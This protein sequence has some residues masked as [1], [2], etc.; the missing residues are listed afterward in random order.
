MAGTYTGAP[1]RREREKAPVRA[2][3]LLALGLV[4]VG[5][6]PAEAAPGWSSAP[7][8]NLPRE[9]PPACKRWKHRHG[10]VTALGRVECASEADAPALPSPTPS[11]APQPRPTERPTGGPGVAPTPTPVPAPSPAPAPA[12]SRPPAPRPSP[13]GRAPPPIAGYP[14]ANALMAMD[15]RQ[16][17]AY[18]R[19]QEVPFT[20]LTRREAPE[21]AIPVRLSG[22]IAGVAWTIPWSK[23]EASDPHTIWDCRMVAAVVPITRWLASHGVTEIAY[24]SSLRRG[25]PKSKSQHNAGLAVDFLGFRRGGED[26]AKVEETYPRRRLR[27]C[28][29]LAEAPALGAD[30]GDVYLALVCEAIRGGLFHTILTPDH[31]RAHHNHL[32]LDVKAGQRSPVDPYVSYAG[33]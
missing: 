14:D 31:D 27:S 24:F 33:R 8:W 13:A 6:R 9:R 21:V 4:L 20:A 10:K 28:P 29:A 18:L 5:A 3:A 17:H 26:L 25:A 19:E 32:H 30:P 22:P 11:A 15:R 23:D 1:P 12:T 16:C 2:L 7:R